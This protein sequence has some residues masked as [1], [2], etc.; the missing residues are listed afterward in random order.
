V[1]ALGSLGGKILVL[2]F[3]LGVVA[4]PGIPGARAKYAATRADDDD[5]GKRQRIAELT[6]QVNTRVAQE[7]WT[8]AANAQQKKA[9]L[10]MELR[11]ASLAE[12]VEAYGLLRD[13]QLNTGLFDETIATAKQVETLMQTPG[14]ALPRWRLAEASARRAFIERIKGLDD[15]GRA[16]LITAI[17]TYDF[18]M[19]QAAQKQRKDA[20]GWAEQSREIKRQLLGADSPEVAEIELKLGIW[21]YQQGQ[22]QESIARLRE[23]IR[24][25]HKV[26]GDDHPDTA[27][28]LFALGT[29]KTD[30]DNRGG[31][32]TAGL[33]DIE[34]ALKI[35]RAARGDAH[36]D[37]QRCFRELIVRGLGTSRHDR[38]RSL[39]KEFVKVVRSAFPNEPFRP[40]E[41]LHLLAFAYNH[42]TE[43]AI[44]EA[45]LREILDIIR[46]HRKPELKDSLAR[47]EG[48]VLIQIGLVRQKAHN[49]DQAGE[50]YRQAQAIYERV[51]TDPHQR[52]MDADLAYL[53]TVLS[54]W[55]QQRNEIAQA[56][57]ALDEARMIQANRQQVGE[58]ASGEVALLLEQSARLAH[59][60][61]DLQQAKQDMESAI[62]YW[63]MIRGAVLPA[64]ARR[65]SEIGLIEYQMGDRQ[66]AAVSFTEAVRQ[67]EAAAPT[68]PDAIW[69]LRGRGDFRFETGDAAGAL[70]DYRR[71]LDVYLGFSADLLAQ[72]S[73]ADMIVAAR[74]GGSIRD[75]LLSVLKPVGGE[76][77]RQA[78]DVVW[79]TRGMA[80]QV[81][82]E[83][84][85]AAAVAPG[86]RALMDRLAAVRAELAR[87]T[88]TVVR[89]EQAEAHVATL[90]EL[91]E[92]KTQLDRDLTVASAPFARRRAGLTASPKELAKLVPPGV[93][94]VDILRTERYRP[95]GDMKTIL[96]S[97]S[98]YEAFVL[99]A[100]DSEPGYE[101]ERIELPGEAVSVERAVIQW[102]RA[103]DGLD[104]A[105]RDFGQAVRKA[106]WAP[107]EK[108]L[109]GRRTVIILPD[110]ALAEIPWC[111]IPGSQ[112][113]SVLLDEYAIATALTGK[114]LVSLLGSSSATPIPPPAKD[115][116][117]VGDVDYGPV[118]AV[119]EACRPLKFSGEEVAQVSHLHGRPERQTLLEGRAA[120]VGAVM[121]ELPKHRIALLSTH[122]SSSHTRVV[123]DLSA[124]G[125]ATAEIRLPSFQ[126]NRDDTLERNPLLVSRMLLAGANEPPSWAA[127]L[128]GDQI[129]GLDLT[130]LDLAVLSAC[131]TAVGLSSIGEGIHSLL[132]A[133]LLAGARTV[134][135]TLW[136][137]DDRATALLVEEFF[138][139]LW[140]SRRSGVAA[141]NP[142]GK[143]EALR[144]A[145][146]TVRAHY[147]A[148]LRRLVRAH[149]PV[150]ALPGK[151]VPALPQGAPLPTYYWAA[152]VLSGDWR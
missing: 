58:A 62:R 89:P 129:A 72:L 121:Q 145:Q 116:L 78:Y 52:A 25:R 94:L 3:V 81:V 41:P 147:D 63:A 59:T 140:A 132:R 67:V 99:H 65:R 68:N 35:F 109:G 119:G 56:R 39:A 84:G 131:E 64:N 86:Q 95:A 47:R 70:A 31:D 48:M 114:H 111:A 29:V 44:Q 22:F 57:K 36:E 82:A 28:A 120:T 9:E 21:Y 5:D 142:V 1:N 127:V 152:F 71:A 24:V 26:L 85:L 107:I 11:S 124:G 14:A 125:A 115:L 45:Y 104:P 55:H 134:V 126:R 32:F 6:K 61:G 122:A 141:T 96:R 118:P 2:A 143:L 146:Q 128:T 110:F 60:A 87:A 34:Q 74:E 42:P 148:K 54:Q 80:T 20:I 150:D 7:H 77:V 91:N 136:E 53:L 12:R 117:L 108:A 149:E 19:K 151:P 97:E 37:T 112:P 51:I 90:H 144:R 101:V 79:Q 43:L 98:R 33:D 69:C 76:P 49:Y 83:R 46:A 113:S 40:I 30:P 38:Y 133:C 93:V 100:I 123:G 130:R 137:V 50:Y 106:V 15:R 102:R 4:V 73:E 139:E 75:R 88:W 92:R 105:E 135:S 16:R 27:Q 103:I 23:A 10:L 18:A 66:Q 138:R 17:R 8:D 13:I